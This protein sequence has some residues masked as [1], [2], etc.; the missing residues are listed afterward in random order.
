MVGASDQI[1]AKEGPLT[2]QEFDEVRAHVTVGSQILTPMPGMGEVASFVRHHH[3]RW[4]G[5]GYPDRLIGDAAPWVSP[6]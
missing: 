1:L 2:P 4:D 3:E 5:Q 6:E